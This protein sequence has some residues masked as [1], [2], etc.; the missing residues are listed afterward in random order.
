MVTRSGKRIS[1]TD[2]LIR[3][4]VPA[5]ASDN[6]LLF[7]VELGLRGASSASKIRFPK[8]SLHHLTVCRECLCLWKVASRKGHKKLKDMDVHTSDSSAVCSLL[9]LKPFLVL[10]TYT[11]FWVPRSLECAHSCRVGVAEDISVFSASFPDQTD[12]WLIL[13]VVICLS[14]RLSHA[15]LSINNF[16][17]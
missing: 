11:R 2:S 4:S 15:C 12:T 6:L 14:Q 9:Y 8:A 13:P 16:I 10:K 5:P 7:A 1:L 17:L 3:V